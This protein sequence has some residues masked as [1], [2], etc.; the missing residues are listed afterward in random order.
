[1]KTEKKE[2]SYYRL[3]LETYLKDYHPHRLGDERFIAERSDASAKVYE[4]S[5]L[6]G[7]TPAEAD[8]T[9]LQVLFEGLHFSE[10]FLSSKFSITNFQPKC[11]PNLPRN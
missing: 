7:A 6:A 9:A 4:E 8:E 5:F 3:R 2:L 10:F 11:L 1:M